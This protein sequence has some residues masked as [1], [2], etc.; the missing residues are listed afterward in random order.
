M[1]LPGPDHP[2]TIER[3]PR[4]LR[5]LFGGVTIVESADALALREASYPPVLY[6]PR[7]DADLSFFAA[8]PRRSHCPYKGEAFY[9]HLRTHDRRE[10]NVVWSYERPYPSV[11]QIAGRLAFY[12]DK[13]EIAQA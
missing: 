5:V 4:R 1:K 11:A 12:A 2:I 3:D 10:E 13:V 7:D 9:F 6:F 8:S